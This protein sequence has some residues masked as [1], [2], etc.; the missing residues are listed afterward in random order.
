MTLEHN[1]QVLYVRLTHEFLQ[2]P[3]G[4]LPRF[5]FATREVAGTA[6]LVDGRSLDDG[7]KELFDVEG[8]LFVFQK[9][10]DSLHEGLG[11]APPTRVI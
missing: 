1:K 3:V 8:R 5:F 7:E 9:G 2:K 11:V 6:E 4:G 10:Q